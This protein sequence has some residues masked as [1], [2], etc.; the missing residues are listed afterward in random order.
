MF[1]F[2]FCSVIEGTE[3]YAALLY[4]RIPSYR[5]PPLLGRGCTGGD[6][7]G[8]ILLHLGDSVEEKRRRHAREEAAEPGVR[9]AQCERWRLAS[10]ERKEARCASTGAMSKYRRHEQALKVLLSLCWIYLHTS[11]SHTFAWFA[12]Y[13]FK[14]FYI[15]EELILRRNGHHWKG[16]AMKGELY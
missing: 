13:K 9:E 14:C 5:Q 8:C 7:V 3:C 15:S 6:S 10:G 12:V 2:Q 11:N 1:I 4:T 16:K